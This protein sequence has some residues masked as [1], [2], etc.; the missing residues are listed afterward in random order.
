MKKL[1]LQEIQQRAGDEPTEG[2]G[3]NSEVFLM[4]W[5]QLGPDNILVGTHDGRFTAFVPPRT[6]HTFNSL[7]DAKEWVAG[8]DARERKVCVC[9]DL[10]GSMKPFNLRKKDVKYFGNAKVISLR[11]NW[12]LGDWVP[13][14]TYAISELR[15]QKS[16]R[17]EAAGFQ[18]YVVPKVIDLT[19]E[20]IEVDGLVPAEGGTS[21]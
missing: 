3:G 16:Q 15:R 1:T 18:G 17:E 20:G 13:G 4:N 14:H 19:K 11:L 12:P 9:F 21:Q 6:V 8:D 10:M 7:E 2:G 5:T